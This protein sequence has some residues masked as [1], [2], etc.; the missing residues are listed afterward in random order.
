MVLQTVIKKQCP[1]ATYIHRSAHKLNVDVSKQVRA[2]SDFFA[3]LQ[4]AYIF[5]SS[6]KCHDLFLSI[7]QAGESNKTENDRM[8]FELEKNCT[9]SVA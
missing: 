1:Q 9:K 7:Q 6:S 3:H 2:A 8:I 5:F 4:S